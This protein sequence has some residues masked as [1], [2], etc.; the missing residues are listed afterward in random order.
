VKKRSMR[1]R[2][3]GHLKRQWVTP[4]DALRLVGCLSLSQRVGELER[5]GHTLDRKWINTTSGKRVRAYRIVKPTR[6]TA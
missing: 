2:L 3:I 4:L 1:E 5:E 6:W